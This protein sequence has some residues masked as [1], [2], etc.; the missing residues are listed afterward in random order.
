MRNKE[1]QEM[2]SLRITKYYIQ[3]KTNWPY[4]K[5]DEI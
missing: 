5:V 4:Y 2:G 3:C 1:G